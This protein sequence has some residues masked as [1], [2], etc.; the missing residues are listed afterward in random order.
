[1]VKTEL[2]IYGRVLMRKGGTGDEK[3]Q[4]HRCQNRRQLDKTGSMMEMC[5]FVLFHD[6]QT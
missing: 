3:G 4:G 1:M 6:I 2:Q 5:S